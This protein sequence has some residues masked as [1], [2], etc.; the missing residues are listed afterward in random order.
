MRLTKGLHFAFEVESENHGTIHVHTASIARAT[1][2]AYYAEL[3]AAFE[4][5]FN[6]GDPMT[7]VVTGPRIAYAAMKAAATARGTWETPRDK[8]GATIANAPT[9]VQDGLINELIRL[10]TI[11]CASEGGGWQPLPMA[12]AI[13]RGILDEEAHYEILGLLCFFSAASKVG[14]RDVVQDMMTMMEEAGKWQFGSWNSTA[15]VASLPIS[16]P[17]ESTTMKPSS[18]IA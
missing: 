15:Y 18:V 10:T 16:M 11:A 1:F 4:A 12:T 13:A 6:A 8:S 3:K 14:P 9:N 2:E 17:D 7:F 5:C